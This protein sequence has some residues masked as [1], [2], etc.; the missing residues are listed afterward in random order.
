MADDAKGGT[1][2]FAKEILPASSNAWEV[3]NFILFES[4]VIAVLMMIL[5]VS[6]RRSVVIDV[7]GWI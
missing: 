5:N 1:K 2:A 3:G 4:Y 6:M 7:E